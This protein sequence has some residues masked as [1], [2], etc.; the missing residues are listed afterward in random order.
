ME[1]QVA[2]IGKGMES[3]VQWAAVRVGGWVDV[4]GGVGWGGGGGDAV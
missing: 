1:Y 3:P 4:R 2:G